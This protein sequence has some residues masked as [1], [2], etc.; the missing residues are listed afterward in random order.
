M[1]SQPPLTRVRPGCSA[2][3]RRGS[4]AK[5]AA[6][7]TSPRSLASSSLEGPLEAGWRGWLKGAG[8][9]PGIP[10]RWWRLQAV[11]VCF[12]RGSQCGGDCGRP[13]TCPY[14][15]GGRQGGC[16][17]PWGWVSSSQNSLEFTPFQWAFKHQSG[18]FIHSVPTQRPHRRWGCYVA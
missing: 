12:P 4:G 8:L 10:L 2:R 13:C 18:S 15:V 14:P 6:R 16:E 5:C 7:G 1:G 17:S 11:R 9:S 3:G